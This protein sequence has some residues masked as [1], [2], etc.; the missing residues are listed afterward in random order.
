MEPV[1]NV[2]AYAYDLMCDEFPNEVEGITFSVFAAV[3]ASTLTAAQ[4]LGM[5]LSSPEADARDAQLYDD[6]YAAG[7]GDGYEDCA[8]DY[9]QDGALFDMEAEEP[10]FPFQVQAAYNSGF[11]LGYSEGFDEG[12][13]SGVGDLD[14]D[15]DC[16]ED[17]DEDSDEED[18][19]YGDEDEDED[20]DEE[21][22]FLGCQGDSDEDDD[23]TDLDE[24]FCDDEDCLG[25][26]AKDCL[27]CRYDLD[28]DD[29]LM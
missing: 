26:D 24:A 5:V 22:D 19:W 29:L 16:D 7:Y 8:E 1:F 21:E 18:F 20:S 13:C 3:V 23:F 2:S 10:E 4:E 6:A 28:E 9:Y 12:Y 27:G 25:C 17:L 14:E 15:L 11:S